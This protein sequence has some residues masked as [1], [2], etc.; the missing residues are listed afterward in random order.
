MG[1]DIQIFIEQRRS[2]SRW[3]SLGVLPVDRDYEVFDALTSARRGMPTDPSPITEGANQ[4]F[5]NPGPKESDNECTSAEAAELVA[6]GDCRWV[7]AE[8]HWITA[9]DHHDHSW[10]TL[11]E[12]TDALA[13]I[14][15]PSDQYH[16]LSAYGQSLR[17]R[18]WEVRFV[19]WLKG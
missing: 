13:P 19:F 17:S 14:A 1:A 11:D 3:L 10:M 5:V 12:W 16:A 9:P 7:D 4:W 18:G 15:N 2:G 6:N 8:H